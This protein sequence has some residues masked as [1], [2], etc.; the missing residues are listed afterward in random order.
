[1]VKKIN[2]SEGDCFSIPLREGGFARG[3]VARM[4]EEGIVFGY[5]FG[6]KIEEFTG[7]YVDDLR[8]EQAILSG[9]FGDLGLLNEE[10]KVIGKVPDWSR[11]RWAMPSF[12]RF[13]EGV[14]TGFLST[15]DE[16][17]LKCINEK[18]IKLSEINV[19]DFPKDSVMGYGFVEI[20]LTKLLSTQ[21]EQ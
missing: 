1:M 7:L 8:P 14:S 21:I 13:N 16:D 17:S 20:K 6:P 19:R 2:Y 18:K 5:F 9:Q 11:G 3:V 10:W 12:L 15:Y 4:N